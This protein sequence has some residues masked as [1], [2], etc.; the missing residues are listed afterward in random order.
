MTHPFS[1]LFAEQGKRVELSKLN[2]AFAFLFCF[3]FLEF[4]QVYILCLPLLPG[5]EMTREKKG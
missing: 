1:S 5:A 3:V 2:E 4:N